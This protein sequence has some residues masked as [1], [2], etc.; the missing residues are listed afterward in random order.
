M[1]GITATRWVGFLAQAGLAS[2]APCRWWLAQVGVTLIDRN[3]PSTAAMRLVADCLKGGEVVG[4]FPEGTRSSDGSIAEFKGGVEFLVRRTKTTVLPIGIDGSQ[5]A[6]PRKAWFP[7]PRKIIVRY[8]QPWPAEKVL[9]EGGLLALRR[10]IAELSGCALAEDLPKNRENVPAAV[11]DGAQCE[12]RN[13]GRDEGPDPNDVRNGPSGT[14]STSP[15]VDP[16]SL[17]PKSLQPKS[18]QPK[19]SQDPSEGPAKQQP[20]AGGGA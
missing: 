19:S 18:L 4:I 11:P 10:E 5:R 12:A 16:L 20:S 17:Q 14:C 1:V 15:M 8:G 6:F 2:F 3:A 9:A 13:R 7:R